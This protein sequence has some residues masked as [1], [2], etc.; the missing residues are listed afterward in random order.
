MNLKTCPYC[1]NPMLGFEIWPSGLSTRLVIE[2]P[3]CRFMI[4]LPIDFPDMT[5]RE[6]IFKKA[7]AIWEEMGTI[8]K[9]WKPI[10]GK[11]CDGK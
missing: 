8:F 11:E 2:C 10:T 1:D 4:A 9:T 7:T 3:S 5:E 6:N